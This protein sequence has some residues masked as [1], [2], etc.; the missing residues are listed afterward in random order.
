MLDLPF[1]SEL[2]QKPF[3][4]LIPLLGSFAFGFQVFEALRLGFAFD[5]AYKFDRKNSP[6]FFWLYIVCFGLFAILCFLLVA[7]CVLVIL[8]HR[9][10]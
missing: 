9:R 6:F 8:T 7:L 10:A 4:L 1:F 3:L 2:S 5:G